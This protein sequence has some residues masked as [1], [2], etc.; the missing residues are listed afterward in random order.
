M[1]SQEC[2]STKGKITKYYTCYSMYKG[3]LSIEFIS[4]KLFSAY[5]IITRRWSIHILY[6]LLHGPKRFRE[7][8]QEINQMSEMMLARRLEDLLKDQ[9]IAKQFTSKE[10]YAIYVLTEKGESLSSFI[11]NLIEW[12]CTSVLREDEDES[13]KNKE[14]G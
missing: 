2:I 6:V 4:E 14:E 10:A 3:R 1:M 12:S 13:M 5:Q 9:L 11:P 8:H 7:I